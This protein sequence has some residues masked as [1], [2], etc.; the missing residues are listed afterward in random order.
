MSK[1]TSTS[2]REAQEK[3]SDQTPDPS[4]KWEGSEEEGGKPQV[5]TPMSDEERKEEWIAA[6]KEKSAEQQA[7]AQEENPIVKTETDPVVKSEAKQ[8]DQSQ[9]E[10]PESEKTRE[11]AE[12][13][14]RELGPLEDRP[15]D[16]IESMLKERGYSDV[17]AD[18]GGTVWTKACPGEYTAAVRIDPADPEAEDGYAN[19][20][21]HAHKEIVKTNEV[22]HGNYDVADQTFDDN[23]N[24]TR[25]KD[26]KKNHI[27]IKPYTIKE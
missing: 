20:V 1:E 5:E 18:S 10:M 6:T 25:A 9:A 3:S 26:Y 19:S 21:D 27:R 17:P 16:E 2:K 14:I 4:L 11:P 15:K 7:S 13:E 24:P 23:G 22:V 12:Q 8:V